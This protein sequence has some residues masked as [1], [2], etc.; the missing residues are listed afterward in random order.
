MRL[1]LSEAEA[2]PRVDELAVVSRDQHIVAL[3][4]LFNPARCGRRVEV[5]NVLGPLSGVGCRLDPD[6]LTPDIGLAGRCH[7]IADHPVSAERRCA[8]RTIRT[9]DGCQLFGCSRGLFEPIW[10][11]RLGD[12]LARMTPRQE[13]RS[14]F[15]VLIREGNDVESSHAA[16]YASLRA[17]QLTRTDGSTAR[18]A[19]S[20]S[21]ASGTMASATSEPRTDETVHDGPA[22]SRV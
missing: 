15:Q 21:S 3:P 8:G 7:Q 11:E 9:P 14:G 10:N 16:G 17:R 1:L 19:G 4:S 12:A 6:I 20:G 22:S 18:S 2:E 13:P 5:A